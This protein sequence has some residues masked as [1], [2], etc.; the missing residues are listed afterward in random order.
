MMLYCLPKA[1][2]RSLDGLSLAYFKDIFSIIAPFFTELYNL[3]ITSGIYPSIW[4]KSIIVPH[5]KVAIPT[6]AADTRP[7]ANLPHFGKVFDSLITQQII[8]YLEEN[9]LISPSQSG[10]RSNHSTET[11]LVKIAEDIRCGADKGLV[12]FLLLFDF[13]RA[14]DSICHELLIYKLKELNFSREAIIWLHSYVTGRSQAVIDTDGSTSRFLPSTSGVPQGSS[15][16]PVI[17]L[18]FINSIISTLRHCSSTCM[19]FADDLQVYI[20]CHPSK[21]EETVAKLN[22]DANAVVGWAKENGLLH[23]YRNDPTYYCRWLSYPAS[24]YSQKC[25]GLFL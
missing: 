19:L 1:R 11:A 15:P 3:S 10:F 6:A 13:K 16:G 12:T 25:R 23:K 21:F 20:Q 9:M 17:F 14:F 2:S 8:S 18:I 24:W 22:E 5:N 7:V 4:K